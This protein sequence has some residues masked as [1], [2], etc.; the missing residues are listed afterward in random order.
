MNFLPG[1]RLEVLDRWTVRF[2]F[3]EPD[4]MALFK[5]ANMHG[6]HTGCWSEPNPPPGPAALPWPG[7][8][9]GKLR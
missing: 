1:A 2:V 4:G 7:S 9:T 5:F 8:P 3:P 6:S